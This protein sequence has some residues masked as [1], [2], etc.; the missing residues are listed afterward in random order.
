VTR[1]GAPRGLDR[2]KPAI[3][4]YFSTGLYSSGSTWVYN[5]ALHLLKLRG[6]VFTI[7]ADQLNVYFEFNTAPAILVK[8]HCPDFSLRFLAKASNSPV[9]LSIRDPRDA[10][11]SY[12]QRFS[13][14]FDVA[15]GHVVGSAEALRCLTDKVETVNFTYEQGFTN[16]PGAIATIAAALDMQLDADLLEQLARRFH[17]DSVRQHIDGLISDGTLPNASP[18]DEFEPET[19]W[20]PGHVG[21]LRINKFQDYL[22]PT[23]VE[24]VTAATAGYCE[25]FGYRV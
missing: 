9:L 17:H 2:S 4:L 18:V 6:N 10:V 24:Q 23:Q 12:M 13:A 21:D 14:P 11:T 1:H 5:V 15:F 19:H 3:Q 25:K 7:Y 8:S 20:H 16:N 22:T